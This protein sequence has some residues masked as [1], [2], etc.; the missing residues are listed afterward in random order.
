[1]I[2]IKMPYEEVYFQRME[3]EKCDKIKSKKNS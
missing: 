1:M 2:L 3:D